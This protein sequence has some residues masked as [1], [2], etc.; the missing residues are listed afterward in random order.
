MAF[1]KRIRKIGKKIL[2]VA[3]KRYVKKGAPNMKNIMSDVK[4]LKSLVNVEKKRVDYTVSARTF[5]QTAGAGVNAY[6][7][8]QITPAIPQGITG[9]TR[10]GNSIKITSACVDLAFSQSVN[11]VNNVKI[12]WLMYVKPDAAPLSSVNSVIQMFEPNPFAGVIDYHSSRDPE[13]FTQFRI[14]KSGVV[15]LRPDSLTGQISYVQLKVPLKL[16]HHL[17]YNTD[18][19]GVTTK[20]QFYFCAVC[21]TGDTIALTGAQLQMNIRWYYTDN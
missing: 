15:N 9:S 17:K 8:E 6:F 4:M 1:R 10:N 19:T 13:F 11:A 3:K 20:N 18:G 21:D 5:G 14:I 12:R 16:N 7:S 2:K